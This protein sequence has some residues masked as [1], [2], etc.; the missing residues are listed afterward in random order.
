[1]GASITQVFDTMN[2]QVIMPIY[3]GIIGILAII[4]L[5]FLVFELIQAFTSGSGSPEKKSHIKQIGIIFVI[6][7][8]AGFAPALVN[9]FISLG[10]GSVPGVNV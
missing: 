1:M 7:L 4:A 10:G 9:W 6:L 3:Y 8:I 5:I 2:N